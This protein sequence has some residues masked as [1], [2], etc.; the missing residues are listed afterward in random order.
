MRHHWKISDYAFRGPKRGTGRR[1]LWKCGPCCAKTEIGWLCHRRALRRHRALAGL[2]L[3]DGLV[4]VHIHVWCNAAKVLFRLDFRLVQ[5]CF[6]QQTDACWM[7]I[8][9]DLRTR[10]TLSRSEGGGF[11]LRNREIQR[12]HGSSRVRIH[13]QLVLD[14]LHPQ[15]KNL[16]QDVLS[17]EEPVLIR[18]SFFVDSLHLKF[19]IVLFSSA[20]VYKFL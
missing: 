6:Q 3:L 16:I 5:L 7:N 1:W 18:I 11:D 12:L 15:G 8:I 4:L 9:I 20:L 17:R 14:Q 2:A 19:L 10:L 13:S